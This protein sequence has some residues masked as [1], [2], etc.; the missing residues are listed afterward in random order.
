VGMIAALEWTRESGVPRF[1][2]SGACAH[3]GS[4]RLSHASYEMEESRKAGISV[5]W[6]FVRSSFAQKNI[7][8]EVYQVSKLPG[9][10]PIDGTCQA[11]KRGHGGAA[12]PPGLK[13]W[14]GR[15]RALQPAYL[16]A[17]TI[18]RQLV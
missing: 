15:T 17:N 8:K 12:A 1:D 4:G 9:P 6:I 2:E 14:H 5:V 18:G 3:D 7:H 16:P 10:L 13:T 11:S